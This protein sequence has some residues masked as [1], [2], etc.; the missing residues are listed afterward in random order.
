MNQKFYFD[1][2]H[3][4][5]LRMVT[6][7]DK[8]LSVVKGAYGSDE[9]S[10]GYWFADMHHLKESKTI[11]NKSYNLIVDFKLKKDLKHKQKLYANMKGRKIYWEDGNVWLQMYA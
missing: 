5:C 4:G 10:K 1:K 9:K 11:D 8:N 7:L 3:G 6:K 2:N